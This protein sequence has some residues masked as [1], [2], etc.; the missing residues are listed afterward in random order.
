VALAPAITTLIALVADLIAE[1][2]ETGEDL[3]MTTIMEA[4]QARTTL[5]QAEVAKTVK[6]V[7]GILAKKDGD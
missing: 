4:A 3:D 2:T 5:R 1:A 6:A 7:M